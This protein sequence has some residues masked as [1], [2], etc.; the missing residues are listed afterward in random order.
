MSLRRL[1]N[2]HFNVRMGNSSML[3]FFEKRPL[4]AG[5]RGKGKL[6][7]SGHKRLT[8]IRFRSTGYANEN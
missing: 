1:W 7:L 2:L 3:S 5:A 4:F 8:K 6:K